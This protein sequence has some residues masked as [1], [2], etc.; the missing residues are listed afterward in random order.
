MDNQE[1]LNPNIPE[2]VRLSRKSTGVPIAKT[3]RNK[4][5][6]DL[7]IELLILE[8]Q[9]RTPLWDFSLPLDQRN[10]ETVRRLWDEVSAELNGK[11]NAAD[12]KK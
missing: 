2:P 1:N 10:R 3:A 9:K 7:D 5:L 12:A 4:Q 11:L 6:T 8:V